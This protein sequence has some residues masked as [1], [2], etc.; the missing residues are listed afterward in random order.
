VI[1]VYGTIS[2]RANMMSKFSGGTSIEQLTSSFRAAMSDPSVKAVVFNVDSP[3][4]SVD[5]VPE[6]AAEIFAAASQKK[7]IAVSDTM[8]ASAAYWLAC[9]LR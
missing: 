7:T 2:R 9:I 5:G 1:P 8:A 4:G 6:L 3:G